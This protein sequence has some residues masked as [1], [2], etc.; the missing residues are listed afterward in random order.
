MISK[1]DLTPNANPL[2]TLVANGGFTGIFRTIGCI[3]DSLSSGEFQS[4]AEN[5]NYNYHDMYDYSW[6]QYIAREA[7]CKVFN[8]S[9]GGMSAR[10]FND[11]FENECGVW[12]EE[13]KCQAY[14]IALGVNDVF[15]DDQTV[16]EVGDCEKPDYSAKN[17]TFAGEYEKIIKKIKT[18]QPKA[19]IFLMTPPRGRKDEKAAEIQALLYSFA[20]AYEF[21]YVIDLFKYAPVY[22]DEFKSMYFLAGHMNPMGYMLTARYVMT[23]ID[24]IIRT[25]SEDFKQVPFIGLPYHCAD[26]KW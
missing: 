5:G 23:Y 24:Y 1:N 22:D 19:R 7:G 25:N 26:A 2:G 3:G 21:T 13:N 9:K 14:I 6:G 12:E 16:G 20:Q 11:S 4:T 18:F 8:F 10:W 17:L 15:N